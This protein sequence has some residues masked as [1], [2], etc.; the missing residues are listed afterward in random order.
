MVDPRLG[1]QA[2]ANEI[3]MDRAI[4][5]AVFVARYRTQVGNE[6]LGDLDALLAQVL[7]KVDTA[8]GDVAGRG[9]GVTTRNRRRLQRLILDL[10]KI[11]GRRYS[12]IR[13]SLSAKMA[14]FAKAEA[15]FQVSAFHSSLP[16]GITLGFT[17]PAAPGLNRIMTARPMLLNGRSGFAADYFGS[18]PKTLVSDVEGA[19]NSGLAAGETPSQLRKRLAGVN[20]SGGVF[21]RTRRDLMTVTRTTVNH[22]SNQARELTYDANSDLVKGVRFVAT[23]DHRTTPI[24]RSLD[25]EVWPID[26]GERPPMHHQCR[27]TTVPVLKSFEELGLGRHFR[28][29]P[30][31]TRASL[32]G[33]VPADL[34]YT[35]WLR[36]QPNSIQDLAL[37]RGRADLFRSGAVMS[38]KDLLGPLNRPLTLDQLLQF[39]GL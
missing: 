25:G 35:D 31:S 16:E 30:A 1:Q 4:R 13:K 23:L 5:H 29:A 9:F 8:L 3:L 14:E 19:I 27:S 15:R 38:M 24:C 34:T 11:T 18:M 26:E 2:T 33:Q 22:V 17:A 20:G 37:G 21:G 39:E 6:L 10:G 36:G 28:D 12:E 32:D 7:R